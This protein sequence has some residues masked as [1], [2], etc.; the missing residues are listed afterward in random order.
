MIYPSDGGAHH[1]VVFRMIMFRPFVGEVMLGTV[2][3]STEDAIQVS[4]DFFDD[5]FIPK[6]SLPADCEFDARHKLWVW[7]FDEGEEGGVFSQHEQIRCRV[8]SIT[9]TRVT[10]TAKGRQATKT[11][12]GLSPSNEIKSSQADTGGSTQGGLGARKR[13]T[14]VDLTDDTSK[15]PLAMQ[16]NASVKLDGLGMRAWNWE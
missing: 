10:N 15:D 12:T 6:Y 1:K 11:S 9:Y 5:V 2:L 8:D 3:R 13:S 4:L 14:S 7:K 16:I